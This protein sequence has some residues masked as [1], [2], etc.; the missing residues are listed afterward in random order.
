MGYG[1][2]LRTYIHGGIYEIGF[3]TEEGLPFVCTPYM[4]AIL[5]GVL[6]TACSMYGMVLIGF[7]VMGNHLHMIVRVDDPQAIPA[8]VG[9]FKRE[10]SHAINNLQGNRRK[11][12]WQEG[13][14]S[15]PILDFESAMNRLVYLY[16]NPAKSD[17]EVSVEAYPGLS[18]WKALT[19]GQTTFRGRR[20]PRETIPELPQRQM[21]HDEEVLLTEQLLKRAYPEEQIEIEPLGFI[22]AFEEGRYVDREKVR[23]DLIE[24]VRSAEAGFARGRKTPVLGAIALRCAS[25]RAAFKPKKFGKRIWCFAATKEKR[26]RFMAWMAERLATRQ[27]LKDTLPFEEFIRYLPEGFFAPGGYLRANINPLLVPF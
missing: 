19:E 9:Y 1:N 8:A 22:D 17:L 14:L 23:A 27:R 24:R 5:M 26:A 18:S 21:T 10:T 11:T 4:E 7:I 6:A 2:T 15:V 20:I 25:I 13:Y 16:S 12:V 3:R